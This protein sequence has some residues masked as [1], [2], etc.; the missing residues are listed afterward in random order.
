MITDYKSRKNEV[1]SSYQ[2]VEFLVSEITENAQRIGLPSPL[3]RLEPLLTD[4]R[5]KAEKIRDDRFSL[6]IAGESKSG[7][8]TFIN[9]YL[10]VEL[11]PMDVKQCTSAIIE[12]KNGEEF[13]VRATYANGKNEEIRGDAAAKEF[14]K[15][16]AALDDKYRDIPVPTIN[17]EILVKSGL[18]AVKKRTTIK[19][20]T[21]DVADFLNASEVQE[22]NIHN[23]P[24]QEYN[25][26]IKDYIEIK[27]NNW[28]AIVTKIEV[29]FPFGEEMRGIEIIDS[30]GVCARGGVAE[31]TSKYIENADA[32]IFLKPVS[33]Q[34]LES[35][36]FNQFMK[37]TSVARNKNALFLVLTRTTNVTKED[38]RRLEDEAYQQFNNINRENILFVD[39]KAELYVKKFADIDDVKSELQ[40]LNKAD[41]L[42]DFVTRAYFDANGNF[43]DVDK[44]NFIKAL[45]EKSRFEQVY[46]ALETFG[47]KAHYLLLVS[48]LDSISNLY[49]TLYNDLKIQMDVYQQKAEDPI[50]LSIKIAA[51]KKELDVIE[52]KMRNGVDEVRQRFRGDDGLIRTAAEKAISDYKKQVSLINENSS[53]AFNE[54]ERESIK[55]IDGF[56]TLTN[57]LQISIITEFDKKLIALS[58]SNMIP[59]ASLRPN[60]TPATF[61][62]I[63]KSTESKATERESYEEGVTFKETYTRSVYSREK[64]YNIIKTNILSRLQIIKDDL[65]SNLTEFIDNVS[66]KYI[67]ELTGNAK[68][69]KKELDA[70]TEAKITAEQIKKITDGLSVLVSRITT[71]QSN[72]GKIKGGIEKNVQ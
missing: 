6:M 67:S 39:S 18:R 1:L 53:D 60:F 65:I 57:E 16:N 34:A 22:A 26:K 59:F 21:S 31:I 3:E 41:T 35:T 37:N 52:D 17:S 7:K 20:P 49:S 11:L 70:I 33:G 68:A 38:L 29:I 47:R 15:K 25:R 44:D 54:L 69:K 9:A 5:M 32:V 28:Q 36:Q 45:A 42:D 51:T 27:K 2:K 4:I 24:V 71:E 63:K 72:A 58:N 62:E 46:N 61:D 55:K 10:G 13:Y 23:I 30:P 8:S 43:G 50:E 64:H 40:R 56:K 66:D 12:I 19:I 48:L 14:L